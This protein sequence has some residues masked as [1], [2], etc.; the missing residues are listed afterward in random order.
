MQRQPTHS[1]PSANGGGSKHPWLGNLFC[2]QRCASPGAA[3]TSLAPPSRKFPAL[4]R[5][6]HLHSMRPSLAALLSMLAAAALL[7]AGPAGADWCAAAT[8]HA[9][10]PRLLTFYLGAALVC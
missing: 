10:P 3:G 9:P 5:P 2:Q 1:T 8:R 6:L 7:A 4:V